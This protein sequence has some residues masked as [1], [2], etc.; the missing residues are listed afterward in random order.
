MPEDTTSTGTMGLLNESLG[1]V[2]VRADAMS[3]RAARLLETFDRLADEL[4]DAGGPLNWDLQ[5]IRLGL[6]V[7]SDDAD[8][9]RSDAHI[10]EDHAEDLAELVQMVERLRTA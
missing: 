1:E 7:L 2:S 9:V 6:E 5:D 10:A 8:L 3:E 4:F